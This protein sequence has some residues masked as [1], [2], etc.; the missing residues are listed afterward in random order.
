MGRKNIK[1]MINY[2]D[3]IS[4]ADLLFPELPGPDDEENELGVGS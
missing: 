2:G 1:T 3:K 4:L